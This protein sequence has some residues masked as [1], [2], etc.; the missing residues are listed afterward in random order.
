[1]RQARF[2]SLD[3]QA[4]REHAFGQFGEDSGLERCDCI[5]PRHTS[6]R[7]EIDP[8]PPDLVQ[9]G[10]AGADHPG[11]ILDV[12]ELAEIGDRQ[13][14]LDRLAE[15][16]LIDRPSKAACKPGRDLFKR[17]DLNPETALSRQF[18]AKRP[19]GQLTVSDDGFPRAV[20][21]LPQQHCN[22]NEYCS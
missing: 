10:G 22:A 20:Q 16:V 7:I 21:S 6:A 19:G 12:V 13:C 17:R 14:L 11:Q 8:G 15:R 9:R 4:G 18:D 5:D 1:M 2:G 3:D